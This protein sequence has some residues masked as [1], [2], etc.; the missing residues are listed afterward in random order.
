MMNFR[1]GNST[2]SLTTWKLHRSG[3]K[4]NGRWHVRHRPW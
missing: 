1:D 2:E 4:Q 3:D